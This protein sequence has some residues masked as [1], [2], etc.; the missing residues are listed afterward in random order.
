[1]QDVGGGG[2]RA[3]I[4]N[5]SLVYKINIGVGTGGGGGGAPGA[6]APPLQPAG[7]GG[8]A[9][10]AMQSHAYPCCTRPDYEISYK[11]SRIS[12]CKVFK[13]FN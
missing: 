12:S 1:M 9:P 8:S 4:S 2:G 10:T 6:R 5:L 7:K 11:I 3:H 13:C